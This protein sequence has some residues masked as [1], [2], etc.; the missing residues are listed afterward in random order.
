MKAAAPLALIAALA[1]AP[2][3]VFAEADAGT[4]PTSSEQSVAPAAEGGG[5]MPGGGCCGS[6]GATNPTTGETPKLECP[7]KRRKR[8][9]EEQRRREAERRESAG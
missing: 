2:A 1:L 6:C 8:L 7:C 5:C 3:L 4:A 9:L